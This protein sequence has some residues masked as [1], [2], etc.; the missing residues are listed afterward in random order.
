MRRSVAVAA[1]ASSL[2]VAVVQS[3]RRR[4]LTE[5]RDRML[6]GMEE[7]AA[8][9]ARVVVFAEGAL[10][11]ADTPAALDTALDAIRSA[12]R[13]RKLYVIIGV[14][15]RNARTQR[16]VN[17]MRPQHWMNWMRARHR[18][19]WMLV[20]G[21]DGRELFRYDKLYDQHDAPMPGVFL[22]DGVPCSAII[23]SDRWLRGIEEIPIQQGA[24]ISFELSNNFPTE[25]VPEFQWY[26]YVPRALRN[27]VW[28]I[29][30]NRAGRRQGQ[31]QMS[32]SLATATAQSLRPTAPSLRTPPRRRA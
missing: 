32:R 29:F 26:W 4:S 18:V 14:S 24:Q 28:V 6:A 21:P 9:G 22:I 8:R 12:A 15:G 30:A 10:G 1:A 17:W 27:N 5:T 25:W 31:L 7:A 23:C 3:V 20:V 13:E 2:R 16:W 19:N 11:G